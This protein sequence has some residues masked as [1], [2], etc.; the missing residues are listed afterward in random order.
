MQKQFIDADFSRRRAHNSLIESLGIYLR[1]V[2]EAKKT[3]LFSD[4]QARKF[5]VWDIGHDARII[6]DDCIVL[7][8]EKTLANRAFVRDWAIASYSAE[9]LKMIDSLIVENK[10]GPLSKK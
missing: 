1:T 9:S 10:N 8:S 6:S 5:V 2:A 4:E 3:G 7:M